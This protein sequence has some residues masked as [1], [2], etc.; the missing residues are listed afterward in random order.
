MSI[1]SEWLK[2]PL[3]SSSS[4]GNQIFNVGFKLPAQLV[5]ATVSPVAA[6]KMNPKIASVS[7]WTKFS[8]ASKV[9]AAA[10]GAY[11][12]L[13]PAA[14]AVPTTTSTSTVSSL[15]A[16]GALDLNILGGGGSQI[17]PASL[18][19][20]SLLAA[21]VKTAAEVAAAKGSGGGLLAGLASLGAT[22]KGF[23][24]GGAPSL[25]NLAGS[26]PGSMVSLA[27]PGI[28]V[29]SGGGAAD[30]G[31]G[32]TD[33]T[34]QPMADNMGAAVETGNSTIWIFAIIAAAGAAWWWWKRKN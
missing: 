17:A 21:P 19:T 15:G 10:V 33:P 6:Y 34:V 3:G 23:L 5:T 4:I 26:V 18:S 9:V 28:T 24:G 31:G 1:L 16:H 12:L 11:A 2:K 8:N 30:P 7:T 20:S 25:A 13:A 32:V 29:E 14:A 22:V 27:T